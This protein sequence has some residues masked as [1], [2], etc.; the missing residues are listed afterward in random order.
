MAAT[1]ALS[2]GLSSAELWSSWQAEVAE[3]GGSLQAGRESREGN[4]LVLQDIWLRSDAETE[5]AP[6]LFLERMTLVSRA[7]G[8]VG[9]RLPEH[10][11]LLLQGP[12]E[13]DAAPR[14]IR[15]SV[16]APG[17]DLA[18]LGLGP[19][20]SFS[21]KAPSLSLALDGIVPPA[22]ISGEEPVLVLALADLNLRYQQDFSAPALS[23]DGE[24]SFGALHGEFRLN[25][26]ASGQLNAMLDLAGGTARLAAAMPPEALAV[27]DQMSQS[28]PDA[29]PDLRP[30]LAALAAGAFFDTATRLDRLELRLELPGEDAPL[31]MDLALNEIQAQ[32]RL[33]KT[34]FLYDYGLKGL[35][36]GLPAA[37]A[38]LPAG[39]GQIGLSLEEFRQSAELGLNALKGKQKWGYRLVLDRLA[40]AE[41][42]WD[43]FDASRLL[44]RDPLTLRIELDGSYGLMPEALAPGWQAAPDSAEP[45]NDLS[46]KIAA[47][48][49]AGL[50]V[51]L[52]GSGG[53]RFDLADLTSYDGFP[54]PE[55]KLHVQTSG[56][57]AQLDRFIAAGMIDADQAK[58]IRAMLMMLAKVGNSPEQLVSD[59]E[60]NGASF[61]LNG[62][63]MR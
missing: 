15:L 42:I 19:R 13:N 1:P 8:S 5:Q 33:D 32:S 25:D 28:A 62:I 16:A 14:Q 60:F 18:I 34:A 11:P 10:F 22:S 61:M 43:I 46:F 35:Q 55:G 21:A 50:G 12:V 4:Q 7:D 26:P 45:L 29:A 56:I 30:A 58:G 53:L 2:Q 40:L 23:L 41:P 44:A 27:L 52:T 59:L 51:G 54:A 48:E 49:I 47:L 24:L 63:K 38:D 3:A 37:L 57:Y 36:L 39:L 31:A 9:I 17:L 20:S 6:S